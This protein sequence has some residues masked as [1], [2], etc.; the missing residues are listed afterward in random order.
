MSGNKGS[1]CD[2]GGKEKATWPELG[3]TKQHKNHRSSLKKSTWRVG[4]L[5]KFLLKN[6]KHHLYKNH[7]Q[8]NTKWND[9]NPKKN[10]F[11]QTAA[12]KNL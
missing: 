11:Q 2:G 9:L 1:S 12:A 3:E 10:I 4:I 5:I 8:K 6:K 7:P